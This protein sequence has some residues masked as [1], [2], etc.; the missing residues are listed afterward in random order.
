MKNFLLIG[1][2]DGTGGAGVIAD[3]RTA[4]ALNLNPYIITT[5]RAVQ[6]N[7]KLFG[8]FYSSKNEI[9]QSLKSVFE[10]SEIEFIKVGMVGNLEIANAILGFIK[11][12]DVKIILDTP[13]KTTSGFEL[14]DI[15]AI[16]SIAEKSFL[17]TPNVEEFEILKQC[18]L[19][20][21]ILVKSFIKGV[22]RLFYN[23]T[24]YK[25][26]TLPPLDIE[27]N[28]RGT[29]CSLACGICSFLFLGESLEVAIK[30]AKQLIYKGMQNAHFNG[31]AYIL[32]FN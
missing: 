22:D 7:K 11:G 10:E 12:K 20:Y 29:G 2:L 8:N 19:K 4:Q 23:K 30:K 28:V 6:N 31:N 25:D 24:E 9:I 13:I 21:P 16:L 27:Y 14:Q 15:N 26:F 17:L 32:N 18:N 3:Y 1:G 5:A